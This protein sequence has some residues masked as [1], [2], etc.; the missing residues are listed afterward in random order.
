MLRGAQ[1]LAHVALDAASQLLHLR[2]ELHGEVIHEFVSV[3]VPLAPDAGGGGPRGAAL[4]RGR[5]D[6][7]REVSVA[8]LDRDARGPSRGRR[9]RGDASQRPRASRVVRSRPTRAR[10]D[11]RD[12]D[13]G[14]RPCRGGAPAPT[15]GRRAPRNRRTR[16]RRA[17][18]HR[19]EQTG[20]SAPRPSLWS[21]KRISQTTS[22]TSLR[23]ARVVRATCLL[24]K[25]SPKFPDR[26][27]RR[28]A[29]D[30]HFRALLGKVDAK[31]TASPVAKSPESPDRIA[32][33]TSREA[34]S[35]LGR[36][37]RLFGFS[38]K[39]APSENLA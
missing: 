18:A 9:G 24:P 8:G 2:R 10:R 16:E 32:R 20:R 15:P 3:S 38:A 13:P 33:W 22:R 14:G 23:R 39:C 27:R 31:S 36:V 6:V 12:R 34:P 7:S 1:V 4:A 5:R 26:R 25:G 37:A 11:A 35:R 21:R 19:G 28:F 30:F 29:R 17:R